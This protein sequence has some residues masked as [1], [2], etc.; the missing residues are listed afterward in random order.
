MPKRKRARY[1]GEWC[2]YSDPPTTS[3]DESIQGTDPK[4]QHN[5]HVKR[6]EPTPAKPPTTPSMPVIP[7]TREN[8]P[9]PPH[10][11]LLE[12]E[13]QA[14]Q[15]RPITSEDNI[16]DTSTTDSIEE[17]AKRWLMVELTHQVSKTATNE[18]WRLAMEIIPRLNNVR[19]TTFGHLRKKMYL[20][21]IHI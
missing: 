11:Q 19:K 6:T 15:D 2:D 17:L 13:F 16:S 7:L 18:F 5:Y 8:T 20:S 9:V 1:L 12:A 10:L 4:S 14:L 3:S 21:L